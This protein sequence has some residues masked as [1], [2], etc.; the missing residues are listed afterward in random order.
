M[1]LSIPIAPSLEGTHHP[2]SPV[3]S[4]KHTIHGAYTY[5]ISQ[6]LAEIQ[7][8]IFVNGPVRTMYILDI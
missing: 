6:V 1:A 5:F 2:S 7:D 8:V 4:E 3:S